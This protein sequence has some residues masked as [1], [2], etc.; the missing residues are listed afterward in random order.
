M[1]SAIGRILVEIFFDE[2][3]QRWDFEVPQLHIVGTGGPTREDAR[4][5]AAEAIAVTLGGQ[6]GSDDNGE[7]EYLRV[8]VG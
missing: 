6:P 2:D 3:T 4:R 5:R 1:A 7:A 8:A